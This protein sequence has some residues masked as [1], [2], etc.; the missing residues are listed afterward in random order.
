MSLE[1]DVALKKGKMSNMVMIDHLDLENDI[2][3]DLDINH[4]LL[5]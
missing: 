5:K 4:L 1:L 3:G 2:D